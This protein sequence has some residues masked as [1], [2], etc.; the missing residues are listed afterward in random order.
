MNKVFLLFGG[1]LGDRSENIRMTKLFINKY[2][3]V[4]LKE[5]KIYET[6]PW[7][8]ECELN[9]LNQVVYLETEKTAQQVLTEV[10]KIELMLGRERSN[11]QWKERTMDID[12]LFYNN[13]VINQ[14]NLIVPHHYLHERRFALIPMA[15][16]NSEFVHP[17]L[18]KTINQLISELTD[19]LIVKPFI[20]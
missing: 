20:K 8:F 5:S 18:N 13:E 15:D 19:T 14:P 9:F 10:L 11:Q 16:I 3:G 6:E 12:I 2:I 17:K 7:G 4:V 1:N